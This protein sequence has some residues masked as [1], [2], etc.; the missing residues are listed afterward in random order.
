[1]DNQ[2]IEED[3]GQIILANVSRAQIYGRNM[4]NTFSPIDMAGCTNISISECTFN[5]N[6]GALYAYGCRDIEI[7]HIEGERLEN[8]IYLEECSKMTV[9]GCRLETSRFAL[10]A[11]NSQDN[12]IRMNEF[13][14]GSPVQFRNSND[15]IIRQNEIIGGLQF[16][17]S[18]RNDIRDN[19]ISS[20]RLDIEDRILLR[21]DQVEPRGNLIE[22]WEVQYFLNRNGE[23]LPVDSDVGG[24]MVYN[25]TDCSLEGADLEGGPGIVVK[26]CTGLAIPRAD[27]LNCGLGIRIEMSYGTRLTECRIQGDMGS[28]GITVWDSDQTRI[29]ECEVYE[30][31]KGMVVDFSSNTDIRDC[32]IERSALN[33]IWLYNITRKSTIIGNYVNG[34]GKNGILLETTNDNLIS[35]NYVTN[36]TSYG[37]LLE[38]NAR[39]NQIYNNRFVLNHGSYEIYDPNLAQADDSGKDNSWYYESSLEKI[40]NYW[41]DLQMPDLNGDGII[42]EPYQIHGRSGSVDKYPMSFGYS[43]PVEDEGRKSGNDLYPTIILLSLIVGLVGFFIWKN[44]SQ[45]RKSS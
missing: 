15:N 36:S 41:T 5:D 20:G 45:S 14:G 42:D 38:T 8:G 16:I 34:S 35:G 7:G 2:L 3:A 39:R 24:A 25:C 23:V 43:K 18:Y 27:L 21:E 9:T 29:V 44:I 11:L 19:S 30:A 10:Q 32:I 33:G 37:M 28:A 1:M 31:N 17:R 40:G 26:Y 12:Y 6:Q 13:A 4:S 22:G